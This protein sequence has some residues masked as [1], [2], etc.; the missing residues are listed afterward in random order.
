MDPIFITHSID[1]LGD[2]LIDTTCGHTTVDYLVESIVDHLVDHLIDPLVELLVD[3]L[4]AFDPLYYV[5][6]NGIN[7]IGSSS[8]SQ[9]APDALASRAV[10]TFG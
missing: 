3:I 7:I 1:P 4:V 2:S 9:C 5:R 8:P 10:V 6:T